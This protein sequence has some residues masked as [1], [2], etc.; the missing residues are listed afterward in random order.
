MSEIEQMLERQARWQ[1][2]RAALS[3]AEKLRLAET[4]RDAALALGGGRRKESS[5]Q[6]GQDSAA[7][8]ESE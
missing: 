7:P 1:Q 5:P 8:K 4:L 6:P 3:W 2:S